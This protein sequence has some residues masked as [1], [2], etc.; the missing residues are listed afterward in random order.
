[1]RFFISISWRKVSHNL[2]VEVYHILGIGMEKKSFLGTLLKFFM[3]LWCIFF[4]QKMHH[5]QYYD[6]FYSDITS[7]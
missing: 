3:W 1:M 4:F 6:N 2:S 5:L 7:V